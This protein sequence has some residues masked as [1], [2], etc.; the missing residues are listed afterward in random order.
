MA[1]SSLSDSPPMAATILIPLAAS[2]WPERQ[3]D[4]ASQEDRDVPLRGTHREAWAFPTPHHV[5]GLPDLSKSS[6]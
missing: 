6:N 3:V 4:W 2:G 1:G 5:M